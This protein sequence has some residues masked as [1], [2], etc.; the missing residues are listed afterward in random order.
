MLAESN[1]P[2]HSRARYLISGRLQLLRR[3]STIADNQQS[4]VRRSSL[5]FVVRKKIKNPVM[6]SRETNYRTG[7]IPR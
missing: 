6:A 7:E 1:D 3:L 4:D 5:K 2:T